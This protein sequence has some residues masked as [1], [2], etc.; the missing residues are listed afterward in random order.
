M[1]EINRLNLENFSGHEYTLAQK[2]MALI[3]KYTEIARVAQNVDLAAEGLEYCITANRIK[4]TPDLN[5]AKVVGQKIEKE[6]H[7]DGYQ[8][9]NL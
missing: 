6:K 4:I 3:S 8:I 5:S 2:D 7:L 1:S 9:G